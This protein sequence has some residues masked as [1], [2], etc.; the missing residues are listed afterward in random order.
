MAGAID[1]VDP[2][3][4]LEK[5][6]GPAPAAVGSAHPVEALASSA[7]DQHDRIGVLHLG[8]DLVFD[9]HLL[10]V[11]YRGRAAGERGAFYSDPEET[12]FGD[13]E[14]LLVEGVEARGGGGGL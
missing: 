3:A 1:Y 2:V 7:V 9:V 12:P 4:L 5:M 14:R 6:S 13:V 8:G 10:A 11:D